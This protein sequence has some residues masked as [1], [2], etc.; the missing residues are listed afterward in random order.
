MTIAE[1]KKVGAG[2]ALAVKTQELPGK[3][4]ELMAEATILANSRVVPLAYIGKPEAVFAVIQYGK[5]LGIGPMTALQNIAFINGRPSLGSELRSA[6]AHKHPEYAGME[7]VE[8]SEKKCVVK[9]YRKFRMMEVVSCFT[10]SFTI[11]EAQRAGLLS[12]SSDSAWSKW[13]KRMLFH[14]ANAFAHQ[15]AFPDVDTG[16][17]TDEEMTPEQFAKYTEEYIKVDDRIVSENLER[18]GKPKQE[19]FVKNLNRDEDESP[20]IAPKRIRKTTK[21][22]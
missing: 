2:K 3:L 7:I 13:T 1:R 12:R 15:D 14:R 5:E 16:V 20:K 18:A 17:H 19:D 6:V 8:S 11:E 21:L 22:V 4:G 9:V 10:G